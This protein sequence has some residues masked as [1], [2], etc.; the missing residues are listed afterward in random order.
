MISK[1]QFRKLTVKYQTT[2]WN[3]AREYLQH[4]FLS[5]F[6]E[7]SQ[8]G[9]IYFKGGTALKLIYG[10]PRFSEDLDFSSNQTTLTLEDIRQIFNNI[11]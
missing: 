5:Y 11:K 8:S 6:Y 1:E 4:I 7:L 9:G 2:E 10:S 3:T